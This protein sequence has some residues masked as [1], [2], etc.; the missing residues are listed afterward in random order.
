MNPAIER[1]AFGSIVVGGVEFTH[2][3]SI[4]LNGDVK[5]RK[6]ELSKKEY[7][8]SH[9]ISKKEAEAVYETGAE[10]LIIGS[11]MFNRVHLS[12]GAQAFLGERGCRVLLHPTGKAAKVWN[13]AEGKV[14]GL[15][16]ITC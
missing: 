12:E 10:L 15:F 5:R 14:L 2:D 13:T 6:K 1:T 3:I 16:H 9:K 7:G 11:G 4:G 8:T